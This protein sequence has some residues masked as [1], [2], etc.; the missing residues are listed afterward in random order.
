MLKWSTLQTVKFY[1]LTIKE[2]DS[3][4]NSYEKNFSTQYFNS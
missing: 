3:N 1:T 2:I 4:V